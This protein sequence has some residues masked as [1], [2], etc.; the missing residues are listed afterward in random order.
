MA[1]F[2]DETWSNLLDAALAAADR[3]YAPYSDF[4][5]GAAILGSDGNVYSG[6]NVE[7]A[8]FGATVCAERHAV[9]AAVL[10]GTTEFDAL[11][12]VCPADRP[13]A[14]CGICRQVLAEFCEDLPILLATPDGQQ[15][16]VDLAELLPH[17]FGSGDFT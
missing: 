12:V 7:N 5:V 15:E 11:V 9:A 10:A 4:H 1:D 16:M 14:P 6:C 17:R 13:V 8:T 3:A 2:D